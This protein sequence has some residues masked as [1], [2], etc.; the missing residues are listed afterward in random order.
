MSPR[1]SVFMPLAMNVFGVV[2][3]LRC[4]GFWNEY[5]AVMLYQPA[6][7]TLATALFRISQGSQNELALIPRLMSACLILLLPVFILF[8]IFHDKMM[9]KLQLGGL[10]E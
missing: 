10:K 3:L 4:I 5:A 8:L 1:L 7:N 6:Y 2:F 9:G